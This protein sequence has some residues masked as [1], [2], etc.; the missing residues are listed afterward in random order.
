MTIIDFHTHL[1][2]AEWGP[3]G[4]RA[5]PGGAF[6]PDIYRRI[7]DPNALLEELAAAGVSLG[8]V[9]T[10]IESLFGVDGP[11]DS[12]VIGDVNDWLAGLVKAHPGQLAALATIDAFSG[13]AGAR[14]AERAILELG[15]SGLVI[16]SSRRGLFLADPSVRPTLEA[17]ARLKVPVFVHPVALPDPGI[18]IAGAR[19]LGT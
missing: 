15:L 6:S 5:R 9:T 1:W 8:V 18:L 7:T 14:E 16:D 12:A 2:P 19:P 17:A 10:T 4:K 3:G 11:V 13:E